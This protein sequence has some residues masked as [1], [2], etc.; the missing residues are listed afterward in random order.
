MIP[1]MNAPK[2]LLIVDPVSSSSVFAERATQNFG[3]DVTAVLSSADLPKDLVD[4]IPHDHLS[5]L[6]VCSDPEE[7]RAAVEEHLGGAPDYLLCGSEPGVELYDHLASVW[8]L[9]P[10]NPGLTQARRDKARMQDALKSHGIRYIPH[11]EA[12][13][14]ES[15]RRWCESQSFGKFV[16]KPLRSSAS[17]GVHICQRPEEAAAATQRLL[18]E[19]DVLGNVIDSVLVEAFIE[20]TEFVV[21]TVSVGGGHRVL[22]VFEYDKEI[23]D[24]VP[25]YR[26]MRALPIDCDS[27]LINYTLQALDALGISDTAAHSEILMDADGPVLVETGARMH[28][29]L[30][31]WLAEMAYSDSLI[32]AAL[33]ARL[34]DSPDQSSHETEVHLENETAE[35]FIASGASGKLAASRVPGFVTRLGS[36]QFDTEKAVV[37]DPVLRTTDLL[38]V[39]C[40]VVLSTPSV[41]VLEKDM[42][43]LRDAVR[44]GDLLDIT[45]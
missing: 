36:Y 21:D 45:R 26:S 22:A 31:P 4:S 15:V 3:L 11:L 12:S 38:S 35:C 25:L 14:A 9:R 18:G 41:A 5:A 34:A 43:E 23:V 7:L 33:T 27:D 32:N 17:Q 10:N 6:F 42:Q 28:G 2:K 29:G 44:R 19:T 37:G 24:G 1:T 20:G 16:V 39:Y 8:Q 30:G 40:R 13:D